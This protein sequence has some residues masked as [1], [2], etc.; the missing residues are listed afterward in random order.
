MAKLWLIISPGGGIQV[1]NGE[2]PQPNDENWAI[3]LVEADNL[4]IKIN[5]VHHTKDIVYNPQQYH[6]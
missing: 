1:L 6:G 4:G 5:C 3:F 2:C